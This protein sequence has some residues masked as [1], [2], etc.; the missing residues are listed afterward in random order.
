LDEVAPE[1]FELRPEFLNLDLLNLSVLQRKDREFFLVKDEIFEEAENRFWEVISEQAQ[2]E[3]KIQMNEITKVMA[4]YKK[5]ESEDDP[6]I[7]EAGERL[8]SLQ[9]R[10]TEVIDYTDKLKTRENEE[11]D[12]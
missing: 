1:K 4:K 5:R 6:R 12:D 9:N 3:M 11:K 10:M 8:Q 7:K 2:E